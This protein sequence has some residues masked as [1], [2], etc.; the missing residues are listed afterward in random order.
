MKS[1]EGK[2]AETYK[3]GSCIEPG[4]IVNAIADGSRIGRQI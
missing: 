3:I 1:L 2:A 4:L